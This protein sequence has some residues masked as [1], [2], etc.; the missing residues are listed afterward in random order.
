MKNQE[1]NAAQMDEI[2]FEHRNKKYGAYILRKM[3]NKQVSKALLLS[4]AIMMAGLAYP[5]V[6]S[7]KLLN[8]YNRSW[9]ET[10]VEVMTNVKP[11]TEPLVLPPAPPSMSEI[12]KQVRFVPP[13]VVDEKV[14]DY[15]GI[16]NQDVLNQT[17]GSDP[18]DLKIE[19]F[20]EKQVSVIEDPEK[21]PPVIAV[22][23][24]P[25]Y[26]GGD[27]ERLKFLSDHIKYP[28]QAT[29]NQIQGTIYFQF[30]ID[31]KGN[32]TDVK[33]LRGIGGGC[34]EEALRVIK[35]MPTWNP[36]R[37]NGRTVRVL[38]NMA[39]IFKIQG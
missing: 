8:K 3:Y 26:P 21:A 4:I 27:S 16:L 23:E 20:V 11:A 32:I 10:G 17:S 35:M 36:G 18:I 24:M 7:Y 25:S 29:E 13:T 1:T 2:V 38:Y 22:E 9:I 39:V 30:V 5:F 15:D 6:S 14:T 31:T 19:K 37:Q 28:I 34:D 33:I 12:K